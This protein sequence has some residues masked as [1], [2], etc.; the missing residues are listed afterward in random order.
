MAVDGGEVVGASGL[1]V[2]LVLG[3][4]L[5]GAVEAGDGLG[6]LGADGDE[7][8]DGGDHEREEHDVGDI[9]AGGEAADY[10]LVGTEVH[11]EGSNDAEDGGRGERHEGLGGERGDD[12]LEEAVGAGGEDVGLALFG[13]VALDDA[14]AAE[15]LGEAAG[16]LGVDL[17][18]LAEDG[19]D[20]LE[21]A[22]EDE[23]EDEQDDEGDDRHLDAELDEVAEGE[24][25][26]EDAA[27]EVDDAGADEVADAFDVGHDAGDEGSGAVLVVEGYGEAAD[28]GLDLHAELGD[29]AL[30]FLREE[31]GEREG[32]YALKDGRAD[33]Y[34]DDD[35]QQIQLVLTHHVVNE[36]FRG[37]W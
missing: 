25:G 31:L 14:D 19:A 12:V 4:D 16:D 5:G 17:G 27:E 10:Y 36:I 18:A 35:R 24:D 32:G 6:E 26:G 20:G 7:L 28:V 8:D 21:G 2:F 13:V 29:E 11:D 30:A 37:S 23:A 34:A 3:E 15:G 33:D 22:L 9:A 1:G